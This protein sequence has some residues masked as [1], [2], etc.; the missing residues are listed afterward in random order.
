MRGSSRPR[1][2]KASPGP[3]LAEYCL[4][5]GRVIV[6][7]VTKE[8][9]AHQPEGPG[10]SYFLQSLL[11]YALDPREHT[12]CQIS[13]LREE[14]SRMAR[15]KA[16]QLDA[17]LAAAQRFL[18]A[19]R[20]SAACGHLR[21]FKNQVRVERAKGLPSPVSDSWVQK[22]ADIGAAIGCK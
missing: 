4:G 19:N 7:T 8:F 2:L 17:K 18:E 20:S 10:P 9:V 12:P 6:D 14:V 21:A 13:G 15:K 3:I 16:S 5:S 1:R 22:A 11:A